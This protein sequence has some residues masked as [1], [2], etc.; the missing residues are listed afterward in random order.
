LV[1][2]DVQEFSANSPLDYAELNKLVLAIKT[3]AAAMPT[4]STTAP[5]VGSTGSA[6]VANSAQTILC[7][8]YQLTNAPALGA[9]GI[10]GNYTV[11]FMRDNKPVTFSSPPH[12]IAWATPTNPGTGMA[13][14]NK[15]G[16]ATT[17]NFPVRGGWVSRSTTGNFYIQYIAI[18]TE[19]PS[20]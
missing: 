18:G 16:V 10:G 13:I 1:S 12:V 4:V 2:V 15:N 11:P 5:A 14:L 17:T 20:S 8:S 19:V 3:I 6:T 7:G 9:K